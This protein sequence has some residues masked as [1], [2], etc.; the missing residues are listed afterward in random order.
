M[1]RMS[2]RPRCGGVFVA[3][4]VL[5]GASVAAAQTLPPL[6]PAP[7]PGAAA[8]LRA[9]LAPRQF[10]TLSSE[11][12]ARIDRIKTRVGERF[13]KGD[14]LVL[15]DCVAQHAAA[16]RARAMQ[17]AAEKTYEI[18]ER[19][20]KLKSIGTLELE[21]S[22][23][24]IA[25]VKAD[26]AVTNDAVSKCTIAAPFSGVTVDQKAREYQYATPGQALLEILDDNDLEVEFIAPSRW[27]RWLAPGYGF[28]VAIDEV[29]KSFA[30]HITRL[31]GRVD[32]VSQSIKVF[33]SIDGPETGLIAGMSGRVS[34]APP[35]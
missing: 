2:L 12:A 17:T 29:D 30:A 34:I 15:F 35:K 19:L 9:Q 16:A 20:A 11:L 28:S 14:V 6:T 3:A 7:P 31:G 8:E 24:E 32:P 25:K 26:V 18:N 23:A 1:Q 33:G 4:I 13:K 10:T 21:V 22:K 27:L 5:L